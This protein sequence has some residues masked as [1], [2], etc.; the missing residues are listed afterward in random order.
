MLVPPSRAVKTSNGPK[1]RAFVKHFF[2]VRTRAVYQETAAGGAPRRR[3]QRKPR[4]RITKGIARS[5]RAR[6]REAPSPTD[7]CPPYMDFGC[8]RGCR[9]PL[10]GSDPRRRCGR[11]TAREPS[12]MASRRGASLHGGACANFECAHDPA[13]GR[14][15]GA[16]CRRY[17]V[18][19]D[20][21]TVFRSEGDLR[22]RSTPWRGT[23]AIGA[24]MDTGRDAPAPQRMTAADRCLQRD[25][26]LE[27]FPDPE[28]HLPSADCHPDA[29]PRCTG[30]CLR[31][32]RVSA[33]AYGLRSGST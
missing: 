11:G 25:R 18:R 26:D 15:A 7:T 27:V 3:V 20:L 19:P 13:S 6:G 14:G 24:G 31:Y 10:R 5:D 9:E 16:M 23:S 21:G 12:P 8:T 32:A 17:S 2:G 30:C 33:A 1:S 29:R 4:C 28:P 22:R